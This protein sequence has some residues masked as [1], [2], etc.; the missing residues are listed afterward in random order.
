MAMIILKL[1]TLGL[2]MLKKNILLF[3]L[4]FTVAISLTIFTG[5]A[6]AQLSE[7]DK[8]PEIKSGLWLPEQK[9]QFKV[10]L[11]IDKDKGNSLKE[12]ALQGHKALKQ[13][14]ETPII[15]SS[16]DKFI[17]TMNCTMPVV[18]KMK[19]VNTE[20]FIKDKLGEIVEVKTS[21]T[22]SYSKPVPGI[23]NNETKTSIIKW[24][25]PCK[26]EKAS[27]ARVAK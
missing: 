11:C 16:E 14:C 27:K 22:T 1:K 15:E 10:D 5:S 7:L 24:S 3:S 4:F 12:F 19:L 25:G 9:N 17:T 18:G 13:F 2:K 8:Y 20:T 6:S 21:S 26:K 23:K